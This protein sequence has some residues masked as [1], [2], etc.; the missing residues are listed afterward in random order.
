MGERYVFRFRVTA[1]DERKERFNYRKDPDNPHE[2]LYDVRSLG[3][4][5]RL[6]GWSSIGPFPD[7]P[8]FEVGQLLRCSLEGVIHEVA[9]A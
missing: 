9:E 8:Q 6:E 4:W 2:T 1:I 3:W 7:K 5:I